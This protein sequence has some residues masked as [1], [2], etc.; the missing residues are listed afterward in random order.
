[1]FDLTQDYWDHVWDSSRTVEIKVV[2]NGVV[3]GSSSQTLT[4]SQIQSF[5]ISDKLMGD[6]KFEV[7]NAV[8]RTFSFTFFDELGT[9]RSVGLGGGSVDLTFTLNGADAYYGRFGINEV[10]E[11]GNNIVTCECVDHMIYANKPYDVT[12]LSYS[13]PKSVYTIA[14]NVASQAGLVLSN[15]SLPNGDILVQNPPDEEMTC[16]QALQYLAQICGC[17]VKAQRQTRP[18]ET[19]NIVFVQPEEAYQSGN[20][21]TVPLNAAF[22]E[23]IA[24]NAVSITG[25]TYGDQS[26]GN[27]GYMVSL[28]E[29]PFLEQVNSSDITTILNT[30]T[31]NYSAISYYPA[32]FTISSNA[33]FETGDIFNITARDGSTKPVIMSQIHISGLSQMACISA[34]A[35]KQQN[36]YV[37]KGGL[38][39]KVSGLIKEVTKIE[40][41]TIPSMVTASERIANALSGYIYIPK[42]NDPYGL[43]EGQ[44]LI[45]DEQIPTNATEVWRWN[46]EG[47]AWSGNVNGNAIA[48][49]YKTAILQ[50]GQIVA[51]FISTGILSS[52]DNV[53][54]INLDDGSFNFGSGKLVYADGNLYA[55]VF[56]SDQIT[57]SNLTVGALSFVAEA[58]GSM[59]LR[60]SE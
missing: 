12:A 24:E 29:N 37:L 54:Q 8:M 39:A 30:L 49:P 57:A 16:R 56:S 51:S 43:V 4:A 41:V 13:N 6:S 19:R 35:T 36:E 31:T 21:V 10:Y 9:V 33:A 2:I 1:M 20:V 46:R 44:I 45:M 47:L 59:S 11:K 53:S 27:S 50:D 60:R 17:F 3:E 18:S 58:D 22:S 32:K 5:N 42:S 14:Q 48:G 38:S 26:S 40:T 55:T 7:G 25:F 15:A 28:P 52:S 34:G 23:D